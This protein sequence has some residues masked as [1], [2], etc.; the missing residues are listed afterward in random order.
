MS[1]DVKAFGLFI[2]KDYL[3]IQLLRCFD[4]YTDPLQ[5]GVMCIHTTQF[6]LISNWPKNKH[7]TG[8]TLVD[9]KGSGLVCLVNIGF[10]GIHDVLYSLEK[11]AE[12]LE[13]RVHFKSMLCEKE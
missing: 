4:F 10:Q 3:P 1:K 13:T 9:K 12:S 11:D 6:I 7:I 2:Y 8:L 5:Y